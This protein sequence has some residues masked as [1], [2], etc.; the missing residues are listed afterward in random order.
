MKILIIHNKYKLVGGED[1]VFYT[2]S[3][4]LSQRGH[5]VEHL[6]FDNGEIKSVFDKLLSG[7]KV[8]YNPE[9]ARVL[10]KKIEHLRPDVIHVHNFIPLISP[11]VFFVAHKYN[12]P[13]VHTLHNFRLVCPSA[14]L[15]YKGKVYEKSIS[16]VF[17]MDAVIKGVYRNSFFQTLAVA[18]MTA[19][20]NLIGTWRNKVTTY[21]ALSYFAKDKFVNSAL[22]IPENKFQV[23]PNSV[24]DCGGSNSPRGDFFLFAGRL[25]EE[26]GLR[27]LIRATKLHNFKLIIIGEGPLSDFI[28]QS[29]KENPNIKYLGFRDRSVIIHHMKTCKALIFPSEWY[30]GYP[31]VL[32]EALSAGAAI[33]VSK[34]GVLPEIVPHNVNG[35]HFETG[36]EHDLVRRII[37]VQQ[38]L[39]NTSEFCRN[40]RA[41]YLE[42][43]SPDKNYVRLMQ[44]Y[45]QAIAAAR[46]TQVRLNSAMVPQLKST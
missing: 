11:S 16:S 46:S 22:S 5:F 36:N 38:H 3:E 30:E 19:F 12:I 24:A 8:I 13:V 45:N 10:R 32:L 1:S 29:A 43:Y 6:V 20:H 7:L 42:N 27:T 40:S 17:P 35:L 34:I 4:L 28:A 33:I 14:T 21:I 31:V 2:E 25:V 39:V 26:K 18:F 37:E 41:R 23:K 9:T 15:F 44:I